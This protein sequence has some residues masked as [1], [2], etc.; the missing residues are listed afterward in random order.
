MLRPP[1]LQPRGR[2]I[3]LEVQDQGI[4][5]APE[6]KER[7]FERF[8]RVTDPRVAEV[9]GTGLGLSLVAHIVQAHQ[10]RISV[11]GAP[12]AGST[13]SVYLPAGK[14]GQGPPADNL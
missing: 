3:V 8:Y 13:F 12:G 10:G 11:Q 14:R 1:L 6:E 7:I 2:G 5:L 9:P 4:G